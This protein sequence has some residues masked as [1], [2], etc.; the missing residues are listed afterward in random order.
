M[1]DASKESVSMVL[2]PRPAI[3]GYTNVDLYKILLVLKMFYEPSI[4]FSTKIHV[5][6]F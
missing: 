6:S 1:V 3:R 2:F 4:P 5:V